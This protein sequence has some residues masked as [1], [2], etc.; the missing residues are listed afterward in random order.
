MK[1]IIVL[2][3]LFPF[4]AKSSEPYII[5]GGDCTFAHRYDPA[6]GDDLSYAFK[7]FRKMAAADLAVVNLEN[8]VTQS[9]LKTEKQ[10]NFKMNKKYLETLKFGGVDIVN[11][12][13]NHVY[14]FGEIGLKETLI[15]LRAAGIGYI[16]AG[17]NIEEA[18]KPLIKTL[19]GRKVAFLGYFG[20]IEPFS[21][22]INKAGTAPRIID[23]IRKDISNIINKGQAEFVV[24][25]YH[26][27]NEGDSIPTDYQIQLARQTIDAGAD[28]IIG[29]HSHVNNGIEKYKNGTIAYSLGNFIFGGNARRS[30][31]TFLL[32]A[33]IKDKHIE[34]EILPVR[35]NNW[36]VFELKGTERQNMI[37][38]IEKLSK[39]IK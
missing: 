25:N 12:A 33:V 7:Y 16:G 22:S 34:T 32:K 26:W 3:I 38:K 18:R 27:G 17:F 24:V 23:Y 19:Q 31:D 20:G 11:C 10:Y 39:M 35:V 21:S 6:A 28:L 8:P 15:N 4:A 13:N 1:Y 36:Q 29:H 30:H 2:F 9:N 14:D 5:F 37:D